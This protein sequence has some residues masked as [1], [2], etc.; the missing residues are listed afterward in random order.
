MMMRVASRFLQSS[1]LATR[2]FTTSVGALEGEL[3]NSKEDF[4][5]KMRPLL[6]VGAAEPSFPSDFLTRAKIGPSDGPTPTKIKLSFTM[7]HKMIMTDEDVSFHPGRPDVTCFANRHASH[8]L[9]SH[10]N[11]KTCILSQVLCSRFP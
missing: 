3:A 2:A 7:P 9:E 11:K 1:G 10:N 8:V 4:L 5:V 6:S